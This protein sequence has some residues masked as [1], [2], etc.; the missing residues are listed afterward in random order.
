MSISDI[1]SI[2]LRCNFSLATR[3]LDFPCVRHK[4]S[5]Q[6][7]EH[8]PFLP[9][10]AAPSLLSPRPTPLRL[11]MLANSYFSYFRCYQGSQAGEENST[12][13]SRGHLGPALV[14]HGGGIHS[15]SR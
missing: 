7:A 15:L 6:A 4:S 9:D 13:P 14:C 11:Q 8:C 12:K 3:V 1:S 10:S 5:K 2:T